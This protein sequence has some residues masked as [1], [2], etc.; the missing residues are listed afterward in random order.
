MAVFRETAQGFF[1]KEVRRGDRGKRFRPAFLHFPFLQTMQ[2]SL[3]RVRQG[4]HGLP[5]F[6]RG[7]YV[8]FQHVLG[9]LLGGFRRPLRLGFR[10]R[11]ALAGHGRS[12]KLHGWGGGARSARR[13]LWPC[14]LWLPRLRI[15][16]AH[17]RN[18]FLHA[19]S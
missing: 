17:F 9:G 4:T 3:F 19:F 2:G 7:L 14:R 8:A 6:F 5:G 11:T 12:G 1:R 18:D 15:G 10:F 13:S 16:P